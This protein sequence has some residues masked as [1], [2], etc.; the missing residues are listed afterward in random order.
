MA[1]LKSSD[2]EKPASSGPYAGQSR[3]QIFES[4]I[5]DDKP[6]I[7]GSTKSGEVVRGLSFDAKTKKLL[8]KIN[9]KKLLK[10]PILQ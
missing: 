8:I 5:K 2:F 6:F 4:K 3:L 1:S 9:K 7:I 10:R